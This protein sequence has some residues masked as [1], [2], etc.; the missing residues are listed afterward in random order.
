M[1]ILSPDSVLRITDA[2]STALAAGIQDARTRLASAASPLMRLMI[3]RDHEVTE[4][5]LLRRELDILRAGREN[6]PPRKRPDYQPAQRLAIL[7]IKV[8]SRTPCS[9]N[10]IALLRRSAAKNGNPEFLIT[11]HGSQFRRKFGRAMKEAGVKHVRSR[12]RSPFLN[13]KI[14]RFFRT[15][16]LWWR[17]VFTGNKPRHI[18]RRLETFADWYNVMRPHSA[19]DSRTPEEAF[20]GK[21]PPKP[22]A[23]R[24][25][26]GPNI[27]IEITRRHYRH[28][29][30]LAVIAITV[31]R[32]A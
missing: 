3:Q 13:G 29:P 30:R 8:Y 27:Q 18:Q 32:A 28:D 7:A 19:L 31:R 15:F 5:E 24:A 17:M 10:L 25:R 12:V 26:D 14:E 4:S 22:V 2:M 23:C 20:R 11:D 9:R 16:K 21:V 6:M 1:A